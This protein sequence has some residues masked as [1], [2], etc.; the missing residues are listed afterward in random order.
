[1]PQNEDLV[2]FLYVDS[3]L[4]FSTRIVIYI[5]CSCNIQYAIRYTLNIIHHLPISMVQV[6]EVH[7]QIVNCN[8][9]NIIRS[10]L[11]SSLVQ[12]DYVCVLV[13]HSTLNHKFH[14]IQLY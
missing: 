4:F 7:V 10:Y 13:S 6:Q 9:S 11:Y 2:G 8:M 14:N 5:V 3:S 12:Y 1:M